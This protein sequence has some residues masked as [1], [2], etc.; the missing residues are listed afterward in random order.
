MKNRRP[1]LPTL[2]GVAVLSFVS[3]AR[4]GD[5]DLTEAGQAVLMEAAKAAQKKDWAVCRTKA[6]G[7]WDKVKHPTVAALLGACEA[8]LGMAREA[9]EHLDFFLQRD[10]GKNPKQTQAAKERFPEVRAKVTLVEVASEPIAEVRVDGTVMGKTPLRVFLEPGDHKVE[11]S[12]FGFNTKTESIAATAGGGRKLDVKLEREGSGT[13]GANGGGGGAPTSAN[14]SAT[15]GA[16]SVEL[17]PPAEKP[18]WPSVLLGGIGAAGVA[19]GIALLVVGTNKHGD[20]EEL[21]TCRPWTRTC[22]AEVNDALDE[23]GGLRAGGVA[24]LAVGGASLVG[25][26]IYLAIPAGP[27]NE[28]AVRLVPLAAPNGSGLTVK[29]TF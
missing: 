16:G 18:V 24:A 23:G 20:A 10:D 6:A 25:M 3:P 15:T 29:G 14:T 27:S 13:G 17:P 8:E 21:A 26:I 28:Q 11:L 4:A 22:E 2:L 5:P 7:V 19:T 1:L 12:A 9:A